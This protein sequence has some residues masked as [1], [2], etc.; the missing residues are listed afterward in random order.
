MGKGQLE[1]GTQVD[2]P[3]ATVLMVGTAVIVATERVL[4]GLHELLG[5]QAS[6]GNLAGIHEDAHH[7]EMAQDDSLV[8]FG[9]RLLGHLGQPVVE[10]WHGGRG[11]PGHH[12]E[13]H[14]VKFDGL[15]VVN[16]D[17]DIG[18]ETQVTNARD[19]VGIVVKAVMVT[20]D[21]MDVELG[22]GLA[23][24]LHGIVQR[25]HRNECTDAENVASE[26]DRID[27]GSFQ[28][29]CQA[30]KVLLLCGNHMVPDG[31][32]VALGGKV[33]VTDNCDFGHKNSSWEE[34]SNFIRIW[35]HHAG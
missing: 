28:L 25:F 11:D 12:V 33:D 18:Q 35:H 2:D 1:R 5:F 34:Y 3:V 9:L 4:G 22:Q 27:P 8:P 15:D 13:L 10:T 6:L 26:Q 20:G 14:P 24:Q 30:V 17:M 23:E 29:G 21:D 31:R 19:I 16:V 7:V 32:D